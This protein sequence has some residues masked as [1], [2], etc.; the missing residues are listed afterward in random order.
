MRVKKFEAKS[1]KEALQMV[2]QELGPDAVI[3]AARDNRRSFGLGGDASVEITAAVS[4]GTLQKKKFTES[5][6]PNSKREQFATA[7]AR[8]QRVVIEKMIEKRDKREEE[9][10]KAAARADARKPITSTS[11]IDILDDEIEP[12]TRRSSA[13]ERA[14]GRSVVDL[15]GEFEAEFKPAAAA[16]ASARQRAQVATE[17]ANVADRAM[18]RIRSAAK[19]A[20]KNNPFMEDEKPAA[21]KPVARA[22]TPS[23]NRVASA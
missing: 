9:E 22:T 21:P 18:A 12:S 10:R 17:E 11:Y 3:L 1:M 16:A 6:L 5:R 4:E 13:L 2:K 20:W 14:S 19:E 7:D 8:T 23:A 15:L